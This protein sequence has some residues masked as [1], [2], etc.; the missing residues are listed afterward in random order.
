MNRYWKKYFWE[1]YGIKIKVIKIHYNPFSFWGVLPSENYV[2]YDYTHGFKHI[3]TDKIFH[4]V[5]EIEEYLK[6]SVDNDK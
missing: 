6:A 2:I 5:K 4:S 1:H 3:I